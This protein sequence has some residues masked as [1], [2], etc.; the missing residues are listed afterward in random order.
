MEQK[1][2]QQVLTCIKPISIKHYFYYS[3]YLSLSTSLTH[4]LAI[5]ISLSTKLSHP[6]LSPH[7]HYTPTPISYS[8][9]L[10]NHQFRILSAVQFSA[11]YG[12]AQKIVQAKIHTGIS[13][14]Y[15]RIIQVSNTFV[16]V[17]TQKL[18]GSEVLVT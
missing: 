10:G 11:I 9:L 17:G 14:L 16:R 6:F 4:T 5:Y 18:L 2:P 12:V 15:T 13:I 7:T 8:H 1:C 3:L